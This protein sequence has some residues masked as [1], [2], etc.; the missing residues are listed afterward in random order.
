LL[1]SGDF[2]SVALMKTALR[3]LKSGGGVV[4]R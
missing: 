1:V 2:L 4:M 3:S